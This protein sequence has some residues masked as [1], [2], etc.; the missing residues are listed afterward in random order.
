[1]E[2][3]TDVWRYDRRPEFLP[4]GKQLV[5][6]LVD[7]NMPPRHYRRWQL[8]GKGRALL[9]DRRCVVRALPSGAKA[10][11]FFS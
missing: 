3:Y 10:R 5:S 9:G 6:A 4:R 7:A 11:L 2:K 1:M 8:I